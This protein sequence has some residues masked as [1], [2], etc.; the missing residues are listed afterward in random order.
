MVFVT[1]TTVGYGDCS[2]V[3]LIGR[4]FGFCCTFYGVI[5]VSITVLVVINTF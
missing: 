5:V 2:P 3:T 1:M 4:S